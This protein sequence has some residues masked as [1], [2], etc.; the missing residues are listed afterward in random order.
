[1]DQQEADSIAVQIGELSAVTRVDAERRAIT[2]LYDATGARLASMRIELDKQVGTIDL[3]GAGA[4]APLSSSAV[5]STDPA[6]QE[7]LNELLYTA[8]LDM[9]SGP[10]PGETLV[11]TAC[12]QAIG[13]CNSEIDPASCAAYCNGCGWAYMDSA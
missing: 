11:S 4:D 3:T 1:M 2:E 10:A 6:Y 9:Q 5:A 8:W 7:A 12:A 13:G